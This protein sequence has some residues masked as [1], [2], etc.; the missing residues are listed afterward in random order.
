MVA[1]FGM[2][3]NPMMKPEN[4][5]AEAGD[6]DATIGTADGDGWED[7]GLEIYYDDDGDAYSYNPVTGET[8]W[9]DSKSDE[10]HE[11]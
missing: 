8:V 4:G 9:L 11:Q 3:F 5:D 2:R 7:G 1:G 6:A 10:E